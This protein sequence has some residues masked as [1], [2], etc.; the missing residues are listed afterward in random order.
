MLNYYQDKLNKITS[1]NHLFTFLI[2]LIRNFSTAPSRLYQSLL[3]PTSCTAD[4]RVL[5]L[6]HHTWQKAK[7]PRKQEQTHPPCPNCPSLMQSQRPI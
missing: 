4:P 6:V 7:Q 1:F 2:S 3:M 5:T